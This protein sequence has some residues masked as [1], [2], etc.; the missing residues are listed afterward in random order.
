MFVEDLKI[1]NHDMFLNVYSFGWTTMV[2]P[3][4][5]H[6]TE[7]YHN[8]KRVLIKDMS[9]Y[10]DSVNITLDMPKW[11]SL[12]LEV[13]SCDKKIND[14]RIAMS[15]MEDAGLKSSAVYNKAYEYVNQL[16]KERDEALATMDEL[17]T[18][19]T[20]NY[21]ERKGFVFNET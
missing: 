9:I 2:F 13:I 3:D 8:L 5:L 6:N 10:G 11:Y 21:V 18:G 7:L 17:I 1:P 15:V 14:A 19:S 16:H 12:R 20:Y 4:V